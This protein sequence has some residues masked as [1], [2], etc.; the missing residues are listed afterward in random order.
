MNTTAYASEFESAM[1]APSVSQLERWGTLAAA[2]ALF[3][4]G[5]SRR[6]AAGF[7]LAAGAAPLAYR[8]VTGRWPAGMSGL[9]TG[10]AD[11]RTALGGA[12]GMH[13]R[14]SV[15]LELP[16]DEVYRFWRR[17]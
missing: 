12:R 15:R 9:L 10:G 1:A 8:G 2:A 5:I 6:D 4:Y 7:C 14:E 3:G 11:S 17:L 16:V 13:V